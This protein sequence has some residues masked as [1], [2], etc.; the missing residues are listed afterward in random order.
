MG[1]RLVPKSV[2]LS[3]FERRTYGRV[4]CVILPYSVAFGT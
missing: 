3:D 2:I 4:F 1:F